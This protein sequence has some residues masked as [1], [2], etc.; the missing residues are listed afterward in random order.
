M[1]EIPPHSS[2]CKT[3]LKKKKERKKQAI[4]NPSCYW[5]SSLNRFKY[6]DKLEL[7]H[8]GQK[9]QE[10]SLLFQRIV[11]VRQKSLMFSCLRAQNSR[12]NYLAIFF[13][14]PPLSGF[15]IR[16]CSDTAW[17]VKAVKWKD[18]AINCSK[19]QAQQNWD[20]RFH[21]CTDWSQVNKSNQVGDEHLLCSSDI[22]DVKCLQRWSS[23][24]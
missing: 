23:D 3:W 22:I 11:A 12:W 2:N 5:S 20:W 15:S 21:I 13:F 1:K 17:E 4:E 18:K 14:L 19:W 10:D 9:L 8:Q 16:T 24:W 6:A 7:H